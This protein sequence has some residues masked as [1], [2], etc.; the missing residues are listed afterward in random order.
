MGVFLGHLGSSLN[1]GLGIS[2]HLITIVV[3]IAIVTSITT[4][5]TIV[6]FALTTNHGVTIELGTT[7]TGGGL[8]AHGSTNRS[9]AHLGSG[10]GHGKGSGHGRPGAWPDGHGQRPGWWPEG[11]G[12]FA[13]VVTPIGDWGEGLLPVGGSEIEACVSLPIEASSV[14]PN[15]ALPIEASSIASNA[16]L[17]VQAWVGRTVFHDDSGSVAGYGASSEIA[18][19]F[20]IGF[21]GYTSTSL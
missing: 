21:S 8:V 14:A 10:R 5:S 12:G 16:A 1:L 6:R 17:P 19:H 13:P 9:A 11:T 3:S 2:L 4:K 20:I 15:A 7:P 18:A